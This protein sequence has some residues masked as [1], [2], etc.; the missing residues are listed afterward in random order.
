MGT[1]SSHSVMVMTP[2]GELVLWTEERIQSLGS[3]FE[4]IEPEKTKYLLP[5]ETFTEERAALSLWRRNL[6]DL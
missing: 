5:L 1:Y 6:M 2:L 4:G 3:G